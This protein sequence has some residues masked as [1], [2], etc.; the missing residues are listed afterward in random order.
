MSELI[1]A[2]KLEPEVF[3]ANIVWVIHRDDIKER[4][5]TYT[6]TLMTGIRMRDW[7]GVDIFPQNPEYRH[8]LVNALRNERYI[9]MLMDVAEGNEFEI[10]NTKSIKDRMIAL[11]RGMDLVDYKDLVLDVDATGNETKSRFLV[12]ND[13]AKEIF[14]WIID[15]IETT[16]LLYDTFPG[17]V[18]HVNTASVVIEDKMIDELEL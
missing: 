13:K 4:F 7:L 10:S 2:E 17:Q 9:D 5:S 15:E 3:T 16:G 8:A 14:L 1:D 12:L 11:L 6:N 18:M